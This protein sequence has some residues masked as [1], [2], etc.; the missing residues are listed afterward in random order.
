M[1]PTRR[2]VIAGAATAAF[3]PLSAIR[4]SAQGPA[5][6]PSQPRSLTP[7]QVRQNH[8]PGLEGA[9]LGAYIL[10]LVAIFYCKIKKIQFFS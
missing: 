7:A 3:V 4:S 1:R 10:S 5:Q 6:N 8:G 9:L 2:T